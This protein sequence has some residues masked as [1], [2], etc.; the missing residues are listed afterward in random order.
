[1]SSGM[2]LLFYR[3]I[4]WCKVNQA[5]KKFLILE[6]RVV[7]EISGFLNAESAEFLK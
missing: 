1:M 2:G 4:V 6:S 3:R 5:Q 7:S